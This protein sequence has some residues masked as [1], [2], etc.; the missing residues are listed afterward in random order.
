VNGLSQRTQ[1]SHQLN[2]IRFLCFLLVFT[3]HFVNNGGN[4]IVGNMNAWWS[5][6]FIQ[7]VSFFGKEGVTLFFVLSGFMLSRPLIQELGSSGKISIVN[8]YSRRVRRI[9]PLYLLFLFILLLINLVSNHSG[10]NS[11]EIPYL[12]TFIY[13][14]GL[15]FDLIGGTRAVITWSLSIEAQLYL[16]F[17]LFLLYRVKNIFLFCATI[18]F[19]SD[20]SL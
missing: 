9:L 12:L 8:F 16:I 18:F 1:H 4:G 13:N 5:E 11:E 7:R 17:P 15:Y 14:W 19:L 6:E 2:L 3:C 20:R 10:F